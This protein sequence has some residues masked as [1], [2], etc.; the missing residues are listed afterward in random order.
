M[1]PTA[2]SRRFIFHTRGVCPPE[3]HFQL[4]DRTVEGIR[5]VG[6]GCP[7]NA[8]MVSRLL[9]GR[10]VAEVLPLLKGIDCRN[11]TSCP[12]QLA[13]A[14]DDALSG[15]LAPADSFRL[16]SDDVPRTRIGLVGEFAGT[17]DQYTAL[18]RHMKSYGVDGVVIVGNITDIPTES[19]AVLGM[20]KR[21]ASAT[22][23]LGD[24]DW[25]LSRS[26]RPDAPGL[27]A[28]DR[29][30]LVRQPQV[31]HFRLGDGSGVAFFG[32]Y[33][34]SL[35]GY[36]DFEPFA[37]EMNMVC[38]L[39]RFMADASVFPALEAMIPQ[40]QTDIILFGQPR[41]WGHWQ[42]GGK[43]FVSIGPAL[44]SDALTWG[45]LESGASGVRFETITV[46]D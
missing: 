7:G 4:H 44:G 32:A 35:D 24:R 23:V 34:Q 8:L 16:K 39:T 13:A 22:L 3:I 11:G 42:V 17:A 45:L 18:D 30:W 27:S 10:P 21:D 33:L 5:F 36:S 25:A 9:E 41:E 43:T 15:R 12:D 29:D 31:F 37:L 6:G 28:K 20:L 2:D 46:G 14:L 40:F 26:D 19:G 38:G 1:I